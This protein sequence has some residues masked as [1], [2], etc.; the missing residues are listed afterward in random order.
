MAKINY[1]Y[2]NLA[3]DIISICNGDTFDTDRM[4]LIK[5]KAEALLATQTKKSEYNA[6]H[7]K[8]STAKG[9]SEKTMAVANAISAVLFNDPLT[10]A[11]INKALGSEYTALQ[12]ANAV[13]YIE[14]VSSTKVVRETTNAK[15]LRSQKEYTAYHR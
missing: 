15:G 4:G 11:D 7:P 12:V 8:K 1:T 3:L 9:A 5:S 13:K 10:T 14:G 6:T 2:C